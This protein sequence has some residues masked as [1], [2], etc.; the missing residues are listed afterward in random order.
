MKRLWFV[1]GIALSSIAVGSDKVEDHTMLVGTEDR[2][3]N[4][5]IRQ[6]Q[7]SLARFL[8]INA[9]PPKGA[10]GFKLKLKF[11]YANGAEHMWVTPF[12]HEGSSFVGILADEPR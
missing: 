5:A 3:M 8:R 9:N 11:K 12:K 4:A 6:A 1:A 2:E 10:S 7:A